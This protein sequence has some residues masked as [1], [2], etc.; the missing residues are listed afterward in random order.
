M[1]VHVIW[2]NLMK[3]QII[4]KFWSLKFLKDR[5]IRQRIHFFKMF[6][7]FK[8][9]SFRVRACHIPSFGLATKA[10]ACKGVGQEKSP[11]VTSRALRSVGEWREWTL[12]FPSELSFWEL[13][14]RCTPELSENHYKG[15]NPLDWNIFYIIGKLL[16]FICLKWACMTS[17]DTSNTSYGQKK[18][19]K[20]TIWLPTIK[21]KESPWFP[22][23]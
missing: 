5:A 23:V 12:T 18:G 14:S 13:K 16:E 1:K 10:R 9:F 17:L 22:C 11:E 21:S 19:R 6:N 15:Q 2:M 7:G 8:N 3:N 4:P 20:L